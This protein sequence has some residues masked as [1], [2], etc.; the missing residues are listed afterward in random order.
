ML[1]TAMLNGWLR[2]ILVRSVRLESRIPMRLNACLDK[3]ANHEVRGC[4]RRRSD[5]PGRDCSRHPRSNAAFRATIRASDAM[6]ARRL[7]ESICTPSRVVLDDVPPAK[8]ADAQWLCRRPPD[9][10]KARAIRQS[11]SHIQAQLRN[12]YVSNQGAL[13]FRILLCGRSLSAPQGGR[14]CFG[15]EEVRGRC[16]LHRLSNAKRHLDRLQ[17]AERFYR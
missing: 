4:D 15:Q 16:R 10:W 11:R 5:A 12:Y 14:V 2:R 17:L 13:P 8:R 7:V 6:E 1:S 3:E 9:Y